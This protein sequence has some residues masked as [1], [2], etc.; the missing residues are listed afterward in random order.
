MINSPLRNYLKSPIM[1]MLKS[2]GL[3]NMKVRSKFDARKKAAKI[4][5]ALSF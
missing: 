2:P 4:I 5:A 3:V 1:I